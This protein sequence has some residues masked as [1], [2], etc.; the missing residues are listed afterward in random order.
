MLLVVLTSDN[1]PCVVFQFRGGA[2]LVRSA[3]GQCL[4][5]LPRIVLFFLHCLLRVLLVWCD[6]MV[7][8][9]DYVVLLLWCDFVCRCGVTM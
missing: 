4:T 6:Y 3:Q 9:C 1:T 7:L 2:G 8:W 5:L